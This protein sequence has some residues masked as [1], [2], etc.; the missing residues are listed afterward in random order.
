M[1]A[2]TSDRVATV[3]DPFVG[4]GTTAVAAQRLGRRFVAGDCSPQAIE[5]AR[6]RLEREAGAHPAPDLLLSRA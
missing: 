6:G 3:L 5:V 4:S 2:A 1:I